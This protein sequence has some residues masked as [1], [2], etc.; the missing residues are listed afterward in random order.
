LLTGDGPPTTRPCIG[1]PNPAGPG[2]WIQRPCGGS[3]Y[4]RLENNQSYVKMWQCDQNQYIY[5]HPG[6]YQFGSG[7]T[8]CD[9]K[10]GFVGVEGLCG[11]KYTCTDYT[12][13]DCNPVGTGFVEAIQNAGEASGQWWR[14]D[15]HCDDYPQDDYGGVQKCNDSI[16]KYTI[17]E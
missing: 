11:A 4:I 7:F 2:N 6:E 12:S 17:T 5:K 9:C 14:T 15:C 3:D 8:E 10:F 13:C 16:I 1:D